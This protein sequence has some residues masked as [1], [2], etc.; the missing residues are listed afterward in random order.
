[1]NKEQVLLRPPEAAARLAVARSTLYLLIAR[2]ELPVVRIGRSV[3]LPVSALDEWVANHTE[4]K[5]SRE[6][7][8]A[9]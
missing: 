9:I 7:I 3:R 6:V 1:M 5:P 2:G 8:G 4:L